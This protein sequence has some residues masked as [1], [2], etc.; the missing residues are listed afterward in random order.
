MTKNFN[1]CPTCYSEGKVTAN[2]NLEEYVFRE[3]SSKADI[4]DQFKIFSSKKG[5]TSAHT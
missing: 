3:Y 2:I 1:M 4:M 5:F